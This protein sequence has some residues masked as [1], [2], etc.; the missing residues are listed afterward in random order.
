MSNLAYLGMAAALSVVGLFALW[1]A[2]RRPR[3]MAAGMK[4]F[5]RELQALAPPEAQAR[6]KEGHVHQGTRPATTVGK[7][8][9]TRRRLE[10]DTSP[11]ARHRTSGGGRRWRATWP[12]IW[13]P[14]TP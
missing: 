2:R 13:A 7:P 4:A 12:S 10:P 1:L 5:S 9:A 8:A 14:P 11:R 3:S 6:R